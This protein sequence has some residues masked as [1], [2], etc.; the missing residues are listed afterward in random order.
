MR[1]ALSAV[2]SLL[3]LLVAKWNCSR[4]SFRQ[5]VIK[6]IGTRVAPCADLHFIV[7]QEPCKS[8]LYR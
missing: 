7:G 2:M 1:R 6:L 4:N 8:C 3:P 5:A